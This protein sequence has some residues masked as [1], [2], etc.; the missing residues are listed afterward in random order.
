M[1]S[2]VTFEK[3]PPDSITF[4]KVEYL[5]LRDEQIAVRRNEGTILQTIGVCSVFDA[6]NWNCLSDNIVY[7]MKDG[8]YKEAALGN[9][10]QEVRKAEPVSAYRYWRHAMSNYFKRA[11]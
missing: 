1:M 8:V 2:G 11:R 7:A 9:E 3:C 4:S 5:I 6:D 10:G